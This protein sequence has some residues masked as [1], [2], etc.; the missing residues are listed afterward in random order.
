MQCGW[1][2]S[3]GGRVPVVVLL[4]VFVLALIVLDT[5]LGLVVLTLL[6][7]VLLI[8]IHGT[9]LLLNWC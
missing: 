3:A 1:W 6:V 2:N 7:V 8:G 4:L 5:V 9:Y